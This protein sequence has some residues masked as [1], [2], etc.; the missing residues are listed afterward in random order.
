MPLAHGCRSSWPS[1]LV[2]TSGTSTT[3][4]PARARSAAI[5]ASASRSQAPTYASYTPPK[6]SF[7][8]C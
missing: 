6:K 8:I 4:P 2:G 7:A 3:A 5:A 1:T